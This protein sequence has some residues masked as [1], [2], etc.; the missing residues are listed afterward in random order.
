MRSDQQV[1]L[2]ISTSLLEPTMKIH[3]S[4]CPIACVEM[5]LFVRLVLFQRILSTRPKF[6]T[7]FVCA[8][9]AQ[10]NEAT[11]HAPLPHAANIKGMDVN[12][13]FVYF[14]WTFPL[15]GGGGTHSP[16]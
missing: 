5:I 16:R 11:R 2:Q 4:H 13:C 8:L 15:F 10:D 14:L 3:G 9:S 7:F 12:M 6:L 1:A